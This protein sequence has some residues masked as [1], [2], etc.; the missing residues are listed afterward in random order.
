MP[1]VYVSIGTNI[2]REKNV[3]SAVDALRRRFGSL[4]VSPVYESKAIGFEGRAFYNLVVGFDTDMSFDALNSFLRSIEDAHGRDRSREKFSSRTLDLDVL[5]YGDLV[6]HRA[7]RDIPRSEI[8]EHAFVLRPLSD[9]AGETRHPESRSTFAEL[10]RDCK[11]GL[12]PLT[13]V[14]MSW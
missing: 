3:R 14:D 11:H 5:L 13:P 4:E 6:D 1:R 7:S 10:W 9:I 2:E 8:I 12:Q